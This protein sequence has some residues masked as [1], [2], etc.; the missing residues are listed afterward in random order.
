MSRS[1]IIFLYAVFH[2]M[3]TRSFKLVYDTE[4]FSTDTSEIPWDTV[5]LSVGMNEKVNNFNDLFLTCLV[6][7]APINL[8]NSAQTQIHLVRTSSTLSH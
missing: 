7:H 1:A 6:Q 8:S 5:N 4:A 2:L 3:V